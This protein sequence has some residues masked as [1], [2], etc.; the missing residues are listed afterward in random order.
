MER[1][2]FGDFLRELEGLEED[3]W[4]FGGGMERVLDDGLKWGM[5][6]DWRDDGEGIE[7]LEEM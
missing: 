4:S 3:W 2:N 1:E 7:C 6:E 5:S